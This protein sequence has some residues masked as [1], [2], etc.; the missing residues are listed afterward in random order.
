MRLV[1]DRTYRF[2]SPVFGLDENDHVIKLEAVGLTNRPALKMP[3]IL[4]N[5]STQDSEISIT[6]T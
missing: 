6:Q 2:L 5:E 3:L 4:N 1:K